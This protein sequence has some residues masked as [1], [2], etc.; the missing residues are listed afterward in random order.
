MKVAAASVRAQVFSCIN[1]IVTCA[2]LTYFI[3]TFIGE[4][5]NN[6]YVFRRNYESG[7]RLWRVVRGSLFAALYSRLFIRSSVFAALYSRL[8]IR[9]FSFAALYSRLFIRGFL[10][11]A[12]YARLCG[13]WCAALY[14]Q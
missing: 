3:I 13:A 2:A 8:C 6:I 5:Y 7:G 14:S 1:P 12:L 10:F 9:G 4:T 11:A